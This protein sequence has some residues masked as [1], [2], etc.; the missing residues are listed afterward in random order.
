[1]KYKLLVVVVVGMLSLSA[2][3]QKSD[4]L[5]YTQPA[6]TWTE[7]L[8]LG[9][10]RLG[11]MV[12]GG[13][14]SELIQL[15][16]C[17]LWSGRPIG[18]NVNPDAYNYLQQT[19]Q[20]LLKEENYTKGFDLA[21]KMQG[22][23][24]ESFEPL[25]NLVIKQ[26][27]KSA[28]PVAYYREL[29]INNAVTTT[30]FTIDGTEFTRQVFISA[31]DNILIVHFKASVAGGLN[32]KVSTNSLLKYNNGIVNNKEI[33]MKG[34]A[35]LHDD[36]HTQKITYEDEKGNKGM[37]YAVFVKATGD[38]TITT[39]A[40]GLAVKNGSD[41]TL[42]L[43]AATSFNGF[44]KDPV[45]QGKDEVK[46]ASQYIDA[47][48]K[49]N[50]QTVFNS[51]VADYH[52]YFN[53]VSFKLGIP[54]DNSNAALPTNERLIGYTNGAKDT[55]LE[56]LYYQF[57]RYLLISCSRPGGTA[58]NLQGIWNDRMLPP[59]S[60]NYTININTQ[61][62]YWPAEMTNLPEMHAPLFDLIKHI[63]QTGKVT[64]TEF[65]H[66]NGWVAHHNSDIWALS[67]PVGVKTGDPAWANWPM[68]GAW[69]CQD[70]WA[71]YQF[72]GNK[73][74]LRNS[75]YPI[76][77]GAAEFC[78]SWLVTDKNGLLVTAPAMS[79]E[80]QFI[81]DEG[82]KGSVSVATT[83][84][85]SIIWDLFTNVIEASDA[86]GIDK[87]FR[88]TII[89]KKA[90]LFPLHI[91]KKGNLQ[92][93]YKDW[94]DEDPHHRHVSHLFGLHPGRQISPITTPA[95]AAAAKRTLE[96]RGDDGTGW[97]LAW[98]IS[99]W[100]RLRDGDHAYTLIRDLL[101][102]A[103]AKNNASMKNKMGDGSGTY[104][105]LFDAHPPFQIDGNFGGVAGMTEL[106]LQSQMNEIDLLPA[107]PDDWDT[108]SIKGLKARGNFE[109]AINWQKHKLTLATIK[110][111][112]GGRCQIRTPSPIK[113]AGQNVTSVKSSI[114]YLTTIQTVKGKT[115]QITP[116]Q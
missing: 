85:M 37:R 77:K 26:A 61:M 10:G 2:M 23:F 86:L 42:Y 99:F 43:S 94:E 104:P 62:N 74:F 55:E 67:N 17:T 47:A 48:A 6:K 19:R 88:D 90:K 71:H 14:D 70:L 97:S 27:F 29:D 65:Y 15:N 33:V 21:R 89:A 16:E 72:T 58:A 84:D 36:Q 116:K 102:A 51:H 30:R 92:E 22:N 32:F 52:H 98:K 64:A 5:W 11:A 41:V 105:N 44:D 107:L 54:A 46:I 8:P 59:W 40:D 50:W 96:L 13:V 1:M 25:G 111:I 31:P 56:T 83:M 78:L 20:A 68:G 57:G 45:K 82:N 113:I 66:A 18:H 110:S 100:G 95:Y 76:M 103:G 9:N 24:S 35:P 34:S 3:A 87:S 75:A 115:Y 12:F 80:N 101:R 39:N 79:P 4:K 73:E 106:L 7:A 93:W 49:K 28:A 109:V 60:S 53:R 112:I 81:D 91:G 108:G 114:G 69:L 63:S 38:G